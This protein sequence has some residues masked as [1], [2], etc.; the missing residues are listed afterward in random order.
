MSAAPRWPTRHDFGDP[1]ADD[2]VDPELAWRA[3]IKRDPLGA[4]PRAELEG[5]VRRFESALGDLLAGRRPTDDSELWALVRALQ[6]DAPFAPDSRGVEL[7]DQPATVPDCV[8]VATNFWPDL[9]GD[10]PDWLLGPWADVLRRPAHEAVFRA[11]LA[12]AAFVPPSAD[13]K[14]AATLLHKREPLPS[15]AERTRFRVI[16]RAPVGLWTL[17][18]RVDAGWRIADRLGLALRRVPPGPVTLRDPVSVCGV[19]PAHGVTMA[20]RLVPTEQ[21]W[22]ACLP[23]LVP[24]EPPIEVVRAWLRLERWRAHLERTRV[25]LEQLLCDRGHVLIRRLHEWAW[26]Q[27]ASSDP[28]APG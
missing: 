22:V 12:A 9:G 11:A 25:S 19:E 13:E 5:R 27:A 17:T 8:R 1:F 7:A 16:D 6:L 18:S 23:F 10:A 20:A 26:V 24:G 4:G 21:G 15:I 28:A 2:P 3:A 14:S